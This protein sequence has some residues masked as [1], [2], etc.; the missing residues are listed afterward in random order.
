MRHSIAEQQHL[1]LP[2][3]LCDSSSLRYPPSSPWRI[4]CSHSC[5]AQFCHLSSVSWQFQRSLNRHSLNKRLLPSLLRPHPLLSRRR[6]ML[7][8]NTIAGNQPHLRHRPPP[9]LRLSP[10]LIPDCSSR[11]TGAASAPIV[12]D[13]R[14]PSP[15]FPASP[16]SSI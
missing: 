16:P 12:A 15:A 5:V 6:L 7:L 1:R 3:S 13:A 14:A 9:S 10:R 11:C 2:S 8:R 4:P